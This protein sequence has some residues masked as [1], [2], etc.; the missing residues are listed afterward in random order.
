M[1]EIQKVQQ[2]CTEAKTASV[3]FAILNTKEK[4]KILD[5]IAK[6]LTENIQSIL[7]ANKADLDAAEENGVPAPMLDR[8]MLN[9]ARINDICDSLY[10]LIKLRDPVGSGEV[11]TTEGGLEICCEKVPLGVVAIIYEARPNVTVDAAALCLKTG[12][13]VV[14]RGGREAVN[15]NLELIRIMKSAIEECGSDPAILGFIEPGAG[16]ES[17]NALMSMRGLVDVLI[18]R[19]SKRLIRAVVDNAKVPVI[20][21]GAG[22]CHLYVDDTADIDMAVKVAINAKCS[23]PAVCNAIETLLVHSSVVA[24]FLP[25]FVKAVSDKY[26]LE[27]RGCERTRKILPCAKVVTEEDFETEYDDF[28][29]AV[30]VVDSI[31]EAIEHI[32]KYNTGHSEAII[33]NSADNANKF[34]KLIDAAAVYV[35]A[36]TRFTDG[37]E[38]GFG[39][40]IG[41]STQKLHARG[42]MGLDAL[43]TQKYLINGNGQVR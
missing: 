11:F 1:T 43:T 24:D 14:L 34:R 10:A 4:N 39:A 3:K 15:T 20:E 16:H 17:A 12:N 28:I 31:D 6:K 23:R 9:E 26:S 18:P 32:N 29:L 36:S 30:K 25:E 27:I 5:A 35:N 7:L 22:N 38:F 13:A 33:T 21:T 8:L 37:G 2:I 42:P 41:I 40:E 19:G